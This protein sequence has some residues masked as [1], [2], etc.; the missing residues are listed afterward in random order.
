MD[1]E[2]PLDRRSEAV[3]RAVSGS[4]MTDKVFPSPQDGEVGDTSGQFALTSVESLVS[5]FGDLESET[6]LSG[7]EIFQST[8]PLPL[9]ITVR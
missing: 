8:R 6:N 1:C 2:K 7:V 4:P 3:Q 9:K 5:E